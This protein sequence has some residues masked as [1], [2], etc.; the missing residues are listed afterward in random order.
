MA[1]LRLEI[2][3]IEGRLFDDQVNMVVAPGSEGVMGILPHHTA[4]LTSLAYGELV[5]KKDGEPNQYFAVGSGFM[6]VQPNSV[7]VLADAAERAGEID[8]ARAEEA[9]K[10]AEET[11]ARAKAERA[12]FSLAEAAL[13][14]SMTRLKVGRRRR[15]G[16]RYTPPPGEY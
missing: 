11:I 12:D 15:K 16:D 6:E 13:R 4:L 5:V 1:T 9:R 2:V 10:R 7:V 8:L 3:T 14:R